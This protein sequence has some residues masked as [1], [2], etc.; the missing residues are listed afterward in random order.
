MKL[1]VAMLACL[2]AAL[3]AVLSAS[4]QD[5]T[6]RYRWT[7]G[8][9]LRYRVSQVGR[10]TI[11]GLPG[12]DDMTVNQ[13]TI[14][15]VRMIVDDVT[16]DGTV[17]LRQTFESV[18]MEMSSP[19]G[20]MVFDSASPDKPAD[21][22]AAAMGTTM[23]AMI[24]ES[25]TIVLSPSGTVTKVE[26]M[27]RIFDKVMKSM[28]QDPMAAQVS[29]QL[30]ASLGDDAMKAMFAQS[31]ATFPDHPVK[32]GETWTGQFPINNPMFGAT[33]TTRTSTLLGIEA[34]IARIGVVL[35]MK[36][37]AG[38][39][40]TNPMG[41]TMNLGDSKSKGEI[42]FDVAKG[43]VVKS[44]LETDLAM[45]MSMPTPDGGKIETKNNGRV[46]VTMEIV[47]K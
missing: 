34:S 1:R 4:G 43:R 44:T 38:A 40:P 36:R 19:A 25:I 45:T 6:L 35:S 9:D 26:G 16:A 24:G 30:K 7:K 27:S 18:R 23:S 46:T 47:D 39:A 10:T 21:P 2:A 11:S 37:D 28:P 5:A 17:T 3:A 29:G 14:Q 8:D 22:V 32:P 12:M 33:T 15:V 42:L 41:M 20:K 13:S 31:F